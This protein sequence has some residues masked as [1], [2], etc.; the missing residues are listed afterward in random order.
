MTI[1]FKLKYYGGTALDSGTHFFGAPCFSK[2]LAKRKF[3]KEEMFIC[4]IN[5]KDLSPFDTEDMLPKEGM[6]YLFYDVFEHTYRA[7][8]EKGEGEVLKEDFNAHFD[9]GKFTA[10]L[11][12]CFSTPTDEKDEAIYGEK[13]FCELPR[14]V[15]DAFPAF[16]KGY[17]CLFLFCPPTFDSFDRQFLIK[18]KNYSCAVISEKDLAAKKFGRI[19]TLNILDTGS[20]AQ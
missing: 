15:K 5:F 7:F 14:M 16:S 9:L 4:Q 19:K 10:P 12:P 1:N 11:K 6:L 13:M 18:V 17:K 8:F 20:A 2:R 3:F